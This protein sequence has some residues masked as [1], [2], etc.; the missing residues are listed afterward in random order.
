MRVERSSAIW[1]V[2]KENDA[3]KVLETGSVWMLQ[4][5]LDPRWTRDFYEA[6]QLM[7]QCLQCCTC[8]LKKVNNKQGNETERFAKSCVDGLRSFFQITD[9]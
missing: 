4:I 3:V 1:L 2:N 8:L 7:K 5:E 9:S 6:K